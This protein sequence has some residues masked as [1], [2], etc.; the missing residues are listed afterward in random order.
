[1]ATI[2]SKTWDAFSADLDGAYSLHRLLQLQRFLA[3]SRSLPTNS[4]T[5]L[6]AHRQMYIDGA[7]AFLAPVL[8]L[9]VT[10]VIEC[11][12]LEPPSGGI[13]NNNSYSI[14]CIVTVMVYTV[15][16]ISE[17]RACVAE[18]ALPLSNRALLVVSIVVAVLDIAVQYG[19]ASAWVFPIPF[20]QL[21]MMPP[22]M[23]LMAICTYIAL[24]IRRV[25]LTKTAPS[26]VAPEKR[27]RYRQHLMKMVQVISIQA[28]GS[29]IYPIYYYFFLS[30]GDRKLHVAQFFLSLLLPAI[31]L[32]QKKR[33]LAITTH[34][35]DLQP[36]FLALNPEL[37]SALFT[38]GCMQNSGSIA[39]TCVLMLMDFAHACH[40]LHSIM[41][42]GTEVD[43]IMAKLGGSC[44]QLVDVAA[45]IVVNDPE[46]RLQIKENSQVR[47]SER[48]R[49]SLDEKE[50]HKCVITLPRRNSSF[51]LWNQAG[52][53]A[54]QS[55]P[56][57]IVP[58][59]DSIPNRVLDSGPSFQ[60]S[61]SVV[62]PANTFSSQCSVIPLPSSPPPPRRNLSVT[63]G[64]QTADSIS[65]DISVLRR[66]E[67]IQLVLST[68]R[69][70]R[71]VETLLLV[72]YI[73]ALIPIGYFVYLRVMYVLPNRQ[74]YPR[75]RTLDDA[76][77]ISISWNLALFGV[78]Q[79][80]SFVLLH[81]TLSKRLQLF[82]GA[83]LAFA[84]GSKRELVAGTLTLWILV[85]LQSTVQHLGTDYSFTFGWMK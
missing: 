60:Q 57:S 9:V 75:L 45:F 78:L 3:A 71:V 29:F 55:S 84:L 47:T 19:V 56:A 31:K 34:M 85:V 70:L 37:F 43:T 64:E 50:P 76:Q 8:S 23:A 30:L 52:R 15:C 28:E 10:L 74:Y 62:H 7:L 48:R 73:E 67:R 44:A 32:V 18:G 21:V 53:F 65:M 17:V 69:L 22:W 41:R 40:S 20:T 25:C 72:E 39:T 51:S 66:D 79:L 14:R 54:S 68:R 82:P 81:I 42:T 36:L 24:L 80:L 26:V 61:I 12:P 11:I 4:Q 58:T 27:R 1:M 63:I 33:L 35:H 59:P 16:V 77:L 6:R 38:I 2:D 49:L 5:S 46:F 83:Q 13:Q